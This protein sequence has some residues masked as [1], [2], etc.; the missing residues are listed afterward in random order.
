MV[1]FGRRFRCTKRRR[2]ADAARRRV[3]EGRAAPMPEY[4]PHIEAA[5]RELRPVLDDELSR[6]PEKYRKPLVLCYLQGL[7]NA[8]AARELGWTKGTVSGRLA[9][10][11]D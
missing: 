11:R 4:D 3:R 7:T 2:R 9:R 10:A 6:L 5:W 1:V 8:E